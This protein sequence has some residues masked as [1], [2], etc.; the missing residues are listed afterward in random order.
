MPEEILIALELCFIPQL[1]MAIVLEPCFKQ[2]ALFGNMK[3][4]Q[5][6]LTHQDVP[7]TLTSTIIP[8]AL[9]TENSVSR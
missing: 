3:N 7:V 5:N 9:K 4:K 2:P 1:N 8:S 6:F